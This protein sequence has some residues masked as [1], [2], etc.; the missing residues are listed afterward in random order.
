MNVM[1][2]SVGVGGGS[3]GVTLNS[4]LFLQYP[5][6]TKITKLVVPGTE[7]LTPFNISSKLIPSAGK[8][9]PSN[10]AILDEFTLP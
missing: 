9:V 3:V 7:T 2:K 10:V 4:I 5:S 6:P 1:H 8:F